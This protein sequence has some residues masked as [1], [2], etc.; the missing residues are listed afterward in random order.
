MAIIAALP[1]HERRKADAMR[2]SRLANALF[3]AQISFQARFGGRADASCLCAGERRLLARLSA[4][5]REDFIR[6]R[7]CARDALSAH[8]PKPPPVLKSADGLPCWPA[9][10]HG[11]IAHGAG[12]A[13]AAVCPAAA[14][15]GVGVDLEPVTALD[16]ALERTI[17]RPEEM[18]GFPGRALAGA[19]SWALLAFAAKEAVY[20]AIYPATRRFLDCHGI[21]V[22]F[23]GDQGPQSGAFVVAGLGEGLQRLAPCVSGRWVRDG[24]FVFA[25]A[26]WRKQ[27]RASS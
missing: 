17:C 8:L 21:S 10:Y 22:R 2:S 9:G 11:S 1:E 4:A 20:K 27:G 19:L 24:Q 13:C 5:R 16:D 14:F 18:A 12:A 26:V 15:A 6:G 23:P 7:Q 3:P 25:G